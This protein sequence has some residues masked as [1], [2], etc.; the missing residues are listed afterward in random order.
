MKSVFLSIR[1]MPGFGAGV[2]LLGILMASLLTACSSTGGGGDKPLETPPET[3]VY[4]IG[5]GDQLQVDVWKHP[6][7]SVVVPVRPDGMISMPLIGD[8]VAS[9]QT[10]DELKGVVTEKLSNYVRTPQVTVIVANPSSSDFQ[11]R[12]RVTGAVNRP[13]TLP[14]RKGMTVMD[15]VLEA[16]GLTDFAAPNRALLYRKNSEGKVMPYAIR[17][18]D[19]FSRGKLETNYPLQPSDVITVPERNF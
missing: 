14:Y 5:V 18:K 6:E 9:E 1:S 17:L 11:R 10:T 2:T 19:I 12:V 7:L 8:V 15:L 13:L 3:A 16:G 4:R